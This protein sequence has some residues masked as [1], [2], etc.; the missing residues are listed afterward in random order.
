S[1]GLM[2]NNP[3]A[4]LRIPRK[5]QPGRDLRPLTEEE[6]N[7]YLEV[8]DLREKLIA[9]LAIFEGMR[10]GE[11]LA[12]RW[13]SFA[14]ETVQVAERVYKRVLNTPKNGKT[15]EGAISDGTL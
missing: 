14:G 7:T 5:C 4:E 12:L 6:V 9:R 1:D 11:I 8:F 3:A 15:R 10:P 13:K 2:L